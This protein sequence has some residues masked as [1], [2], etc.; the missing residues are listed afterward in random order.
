M[1][2]PKLTAFLCA[3]VAEA[4]LAAM[5]LLVMGGDAWGTLALLALAGALADRLVQRALPA[6]RQQIALLA[7]GLLASA[8]AA[9]GAALGDYSLLSGWGTLAENVLSLGRERS[10]LAYGTLLV[11]CYIFWRGTQL[12]VDDNQRLR[13]WFGRALIALLLLV[14]LGTIGYSDPRFFSLIT[15]QMLV[16]FVAG[17][18]MLALTSALEGSR[19]GRLDR[20]ALSSVVVTI[21]MLV[22]L[23][24]LIGVL[25]GEEAGLAVRTLGVGVGLLIGALV[26]PIIFLGFAL[27]QWMLSL[28]GQTEMAARI[29]SM[30]EILNELYRQG[31]TSNQNASIWLGVVINVLACLI[32]L[33]V[34]VGL[35]LLTRRRP[36]RDSSRDEERES[37]WSWNSL[38]DELR[39]LLASLR[40]PPAPHGLRT[41]LAGMRGADPV[42]RVRRS[43]IQLLLRGEGRQ[44]PRRPASTPR[45]YQDVA[46][47]QPAARPA[48]DRLTRAYE[49]ARYHPDATTPADADSAEH[50]WDEIDRADREA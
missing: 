37:V 27:A 28:G 15:A 26:S 3:A 29:S 41:A 7:A 21:A 20:R 36:A 23:G 48:V 6:E 16:F 44:Q 50:A 12:A 45:E 30:A 4:T 39:G 47:D 42:S 46:G 35:Y 13:I 43:Y 10:A 11:A 18:L 2:W 5:V 9:K 25:L 17:M 33:L 1:F 14:G 40:R 8:W 34:I 31:S 22:G 19:Q 32:P 49:R 24:L 38:S